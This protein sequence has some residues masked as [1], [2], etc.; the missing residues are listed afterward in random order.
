MLPV[1]RAPRPRTAALRPLRP[2]LL[3]G[4]ATGL[5]ASVLLTGCAGLH[6]GAAVVVG[7]EVVTEEDLDD[8]SRALC[9]YFEP[10]L[11]QRQQSVPLVEVRRSAAVLLGL[12]SA[13]EQVAEQYDASPG[14]DFNREVA[15]IRGLAERLPEEDREAFLEVQGAQAY[16][17]ITLAE[18]GG[19]VLEAEGAGRGDLSSRTAAGLRAVLAFL[20]REEVEFAP[21]LDLGVEVP[22]VPQAPTLE[23]TSALVGS[24]FVPVDASSSVPVTDVALAGSGGAAD[25]AAGAEG[26][27]ST[28]PADQRCG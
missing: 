19:E 17:P 8:A 10:E 15:R 4:L 18:I 23:E 11:E 28:L 22:E 13:V 12:R 3:A 7:D 2:G 24:I 20:E 16:V 14:S 6:P 9:T 26:A 1:T 5:A 27:G 25:G 21:S